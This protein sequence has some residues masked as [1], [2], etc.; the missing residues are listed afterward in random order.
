M[1]RASAP[2]RR[3]TRRPRSGS[4]ALRGDNG[5]RAVVVDDPNLG[6]IVVPRS[7]M[8]LALTYDHRL[9]DGADAMR[10]LATI[11]DRLEAGHFESELG[12]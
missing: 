4:S 12:L 2:T 7:M 9:L 1:K 3:A 6:E 10:F 5:E 8:Y 11:K